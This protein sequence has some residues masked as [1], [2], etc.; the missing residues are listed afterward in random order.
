MLTVN[1]EANENDI[2][3][4]EAQVIPQQQVQELEVVPQPEET[5]NEDRNNRDITVGDRVLITNSYG[6]RRG[7]T[8]TVIRVSARQVI[9]RLSGSNE[10][11]TKR[12]TSVVVIED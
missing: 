1:R 7:Q 10:V 12:K 11:I 4:V 5:R 6:N 8:G 2:Q 3:V 9:L